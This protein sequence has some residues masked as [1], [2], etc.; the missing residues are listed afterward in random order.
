MQQAVTRARSAG[1]GKDAV[2]GIWRTNYPYFH[3]RPSEVIGR[4]LGKAFVFNNKKIPSLIERD[5]HASCK[6]RHASQS[7]QVPDFLLV[8]TGNSRDGWKKRFLN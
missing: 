3:I 7:L 6:E 2:F 5:W 1:S 8:D 4:G